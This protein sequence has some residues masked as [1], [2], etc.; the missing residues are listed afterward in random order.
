GAL[1]DG[2]AHG[3]Q[4]LP[5]TTLTAMPRMADFALWATACETAFWDAGTFAK[6][7]GQN[8]DEAVDIVIEADLVATAVQKFITELTKAE[9]EGTSSDLLAA[10][11][12]VAGED[13]TKLKEWPQTPRALSSR[14]RLAAPMLR[15][16]GTEITFDRDKRTR[17]IAIARKI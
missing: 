11:K 10:L 13:Q 14:L 9:W 4:Q 2:I 3:L 17:K 7:Y 5:N 16:A 15:K 8:R 1:L 12:N 6:A